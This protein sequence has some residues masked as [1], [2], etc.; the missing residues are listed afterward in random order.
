MPSLLPHL[1]SRR[2]WNSNIIK[3][4]VGTSTETSTIKPATRK[5]KGTL[6]KQHWK[7]FKSQRPGCPLWDSAFYMWQ[8]SFS[9]TTP[10]MWP[11]KKWIIMT[12]PVDMPMWMREISQSLCQMKSYRL[13]TAI[14]RRF[15]VRSYYGMSNLKFCSKHMCIW[16]ALKW[17][18]RFDL[19]MHIYIYM[20]ICV[21]IIITEKK[22]SYEF[23]KCGSE[24]T[25]KK[26][27]GGIK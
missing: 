5:A 20:W 13:L 7:E 12:T 3:L 8:E 10:K 24:R 4:E 6:R 21:S 15:R 26:E 23:E 9:A 16:T 17:L 2:G 14:E 22:R 1:S 19:H 11:S 25:G 27:G 18:N